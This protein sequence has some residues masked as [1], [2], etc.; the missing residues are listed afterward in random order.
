MAATGVSSS[1]R[2]IPYGVSVYHPN[3]LNPAV[4][5]NPNMIQNNTNPQQAFHQMVQ[6]QAELV[7]P[8]HV[9]PTETIT[10]YSN[11]NCTQ[12]VH[13][14]QQQ[15]QHNQG[16]T[17]YEDINSLVGSVGSS[18]S[19]SAQTSVAPVVPDPAGFTV[20]P[21]SPSVWPLTNDD[22][23]PPACIW[24]YADPDPNFFDLDF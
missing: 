21:G 2:Y 10:S 19:L 13:Q 5:Y 8:C 6:Q 15:Q 3:I 14:Q 4:V 18:L 17:L 11:P 7:N 24:D 9:D 12:I 16:S 22:E 1:S 23:Y 20:G